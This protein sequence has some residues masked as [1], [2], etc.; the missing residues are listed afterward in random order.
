MKNVIDV[1]MV[2]DYSA[3]KKNEIITLSGKLK[4]L[5]VI[6]LSKINQKQEEKCHVFSLLCGLLCVSH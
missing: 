3:T 5:E 4:K 1:N 6:T 2:E